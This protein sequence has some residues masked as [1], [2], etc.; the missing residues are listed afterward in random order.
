M[1]KDF[2]LKHI[3]KMLHGLTLEI[4]RIGYLKYCDLLLM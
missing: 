3:V 1:T 4:I 2:E